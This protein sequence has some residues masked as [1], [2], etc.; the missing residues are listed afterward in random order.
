MAAMHQGDIERV[1]AWLVERGLAGAEE[2]ELLH[3]FC[4]QSALKESYVSLSEVLVFAHKNNGGNPKFLRS[5]LIN[6]TI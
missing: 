2:D 1:V 4:E 6:S 5:H 3:G